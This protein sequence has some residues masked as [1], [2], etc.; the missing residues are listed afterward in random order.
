MADSN[1]KIVKLEDMGFV[2]LPP[3]N[4]L[5]N[6]VTSLADMADMTEE[7]KEKLRQAQQDRYKILYGRYNKDK[8][9]L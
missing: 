9:E 6:N 4:K 2:P 7:Q 3:H 1:K 5:I 8:D